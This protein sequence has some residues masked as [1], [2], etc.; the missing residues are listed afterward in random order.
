MRI[1]RLWPVFGALVLLVLTGPPVEAQ[2]GIIQGRVTDQATGQPV[3]SA[4]V[5]VVGTNRQARTAQDGTYELRNV[6][7][8]NVT[9]RATTIGYAAQTQTLA[10]ATGA[11]STANFQLTQAAVSLDALV[12]TA[13]GE[14]RLVEVPNV[15][16]TVNAA[17]VAEEVAPTSLSSL[18]QGRA[19]GVQII[20]GSGSAGS[21]T[22]IRI[23]GSSSMSLTNEPLLVVDG[24]RVDNRQGDGGNVGGQTISR[25]NDFNP[26][27]IESIDIVKGPSAAALYGTAAANGVIVV[28]TKRGRVGA[29]VWN[30]YGEY[31]LVS[32]VNDFPSNF[33]GRDAA[34]S[35]CRTYN[36]AE[37][38]CTQTLLEQANPLESAT[39]SPFRTGRRG[40]VGLNVAGGTPDVQYFISGEIER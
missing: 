28:K 36:L 37:G 1:R 9:I 29:P 17:Q 12:V 10:V 20:N 39:T 35:S 19:T 8:G 40:Q 7:L 6:P 32:D 23:R 27:E 4:L 18:I 14:Q 30:I 34:G 13:T 3:P 38:T 15:I 5:S 21:G 22:Q 24:V 31:G 25:I 26:D 16:A 11:V 2:T 33:T